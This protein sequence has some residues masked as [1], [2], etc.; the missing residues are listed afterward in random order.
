MFIVFL[1]PFL[2][3]LTVYFLK[4]AARIIE[5]CLKELFEFRMM[6]TDPNWTN[7]LW[8]P[9]TRQVRVYDIVTHDGF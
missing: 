6:Q 3:T 8:N 9:K 2:L 5:L 1:L 7:F 4:I